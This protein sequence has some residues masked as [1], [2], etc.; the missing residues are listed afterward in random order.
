M[1]Q[2]LTRRQEEILR[3]LASFQEKM[4]RTPTGPE[5]ARNFGFSDH[6]TAYQHLRVLHQKGYVELI[7][8]GHRQPLGIRLLEKAQALMTHMWPVL[9]AIPAGPLSDLLDDVKRQIH[10]LEDL[11][12]GIRPGD[13][14]LVVD[15][16][17]MIEAGL[18]PGQYVIIRPEVE[19]QQGDICAV[20][21]D[22]EGGTLKRVYAEGELVR[23]VP[24]NPRYQPQTYQVERVRIQGVLV[25]ALAVQSFKR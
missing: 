7:Q 16:D 6:S 18:Q 23:L 8:L 17:S 20:W 25:A 4:G 3:F 9:G 19:P 5:I 14:F 22:G 13:Y 11:V 1:K 12:P 24:A 10:G 2:Q 21:I 15:G